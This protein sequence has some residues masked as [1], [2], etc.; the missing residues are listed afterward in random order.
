MPKVL[1]SLMSQYHF[2]HGHGEMQ[3]GTEVKKFEY[4][5]YHRPIY[6]VW[7]ICSL[8]STAAFLS[9]ILL[10]IMNY[11]SLV[12]ALFV[13]PEYL[14]TTVFGPTFYIL[15][16]FPG[17]MMPIYMGGGGT[18][19]VVYFFLLAALLFGGIGLMIKNE[20]MRFLMLVKATLK[21]KLTPSPRTN[22]SFMLLFQ[23]FMAILFFNMVVVFLHTLIAG[24]SPSVP[25]SLG[26]GVS[27]EQKL[28]MLANA[29]VYE[30]IA[31]RVL[32]IGV[33]LYFVAR[34]TGRKDRPWYRYLLG[35]EMKIGFAA[36]FFSFFSALLFGL[37][38]LQGWGVWKV[39][40][41][42]V[43][44]LAFSYIFLKKGVF[45]AFVF[46]FLF[47]Y[48]GLGRTVLERSSLGLERFD[49]ISVLLLLFWIHVG[50]RYFTHYVL[51]L[52]TTI[53]NDLSDLFDS[54]WKRLQVTFK[55]E[56]VISFVLLMFFWFIT[57]LWMRSQ[58][59]GSDNGNSIVLLDRIL[60]LI[61]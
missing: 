23:L 49:M 17:I 47:D 1:H 52:F 28:Y 19:G 30:E 46:H 13:V 45:P 32:L 10:L 50:I 35:G 56:I 55:T 34:S 41:T 58:I 29:S 27:L 43:S 22:N 25:G 16:P 36:Y 15:V 7:R 2:R 60:M 42:F 9:L 21:R 3:G 26:E 20:G 33:P 37:A 61:S 5:G 54:P 11:W 14:Q 59:G 6:W 31:T 51:R 8:T 24:T 48:L 4:L 57:L 12:Y 44:G 39:L 38:H 53:Y 40:P 18:G